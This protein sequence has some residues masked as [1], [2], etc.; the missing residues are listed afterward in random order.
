MQ[1][2]E[3]CLI[4]IA[5]AIQEALDYVRGMTLEQFAADRKTQAA[6]MYALTVV[7][8]AARRASPA[9]RVKYAQLPWP[10]M[11]GLRNRLVHE[12]DKI[13]LKVVW[14]TLQRDL[15]ALLAA[16]QPVLPQGD[17]QQP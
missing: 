12:Y 3:A 16:I 8:E 9:F 1:R 15:P 7:G 4:D 11:I 10:D 13:K 2:D 17:Q 5:Q 14:E 6:V